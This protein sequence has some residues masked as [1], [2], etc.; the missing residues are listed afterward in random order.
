MA[1]DLVKVDHVYKNKGLCQGDRTR[2]QVLKSF[3]KASHVPSLMLKSDWTVPVTQTY[4]LWYGWASWLGN[5]GQR[6]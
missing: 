2:E 1:N 5:S 4:W 6:E 3:P